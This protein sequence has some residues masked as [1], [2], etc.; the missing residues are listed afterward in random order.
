MRFIG[1]K[2]KLLPFIEGIWRRYIGPE[3][4]RVGDVFCGTAAVSRLFKQLGNRVIANDNLRLGYVFAQATLNINDEPHFERLFASGEIPKGN[5]H[6]LYPTYYDRVLAFL[7]DLP[8]EDGFCF[9]EYSPG[10]TH[11]GSYERRYF[12]DQNAR[13]IDAIRQRLCKWKQFNL[14]T[15]AEFCLLLSNLMRSTNQ[16]A[17]IAGTYGC[18]LKHWDA[19]AQKTLCLQ[20]SPIIRSAFDHQVFC[21]DANELVRDTE[22]DVLYLD[23]P[24]TWRHYGAYYHILET[25]ACGDHPAISGR[26][27][28]RPW[29]DSKSR[30]CDRSDAA[31]ALAEL[32]ICANTKHLFLSYND[33]GLISHEQIMET[34][35][36]RGHPLCLEID[37]RR[38]RSNNG[39]SKRNVLKERLYYVQTQENS[40]PERRSS[41]LAYH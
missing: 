3:T 5:G 19:R 16:V 22:F 6:C 34:L 11:R 27:G 24:Y 25:I 28:L 8:G 32:V 15:E 7:N 30:Y 41:I 1:S 20:R 26:T 29:E 10:G 21:K 14:L 37:Y 12:S 36:T 18:F 31:T 33:E 35:S 39:G 23:P 4:V 9:R 38:Y 40:K 17:N 2:E 13:K